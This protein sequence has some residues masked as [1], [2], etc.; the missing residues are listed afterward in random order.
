MLKKVGSLASAVLLTACATTGGT[1]SDIVPIGKDT[2]MLARPGGFFTISGGEV[3][4]QLYR[5][6]NEFCRSQGKTLMP[7][8]SSSRD[9]APARFA[10]AE[11]QF[12]CLAEGDPDLG[13]PTMKSRPDVT[14]EL[15]QK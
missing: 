10:N 5:D 11:L 4:A 6:A 2:Y 1:V 8:S 12:R 14:I 13:R 15:Q 7:V 9:S 3:K